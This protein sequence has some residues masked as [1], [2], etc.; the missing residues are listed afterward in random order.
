MRADTGVVSEWLVGGVILVALILLLNPFGFIMTSAFILSAI[1]L[2]AVAVISF[3]VFV[4]RE[5]PRDEREVINVSKAGR[6]SYLVGGGVIVA[7]IVYQTITHQLDP[8]L[9]AVLGAMVIT[10]LILAAWYHQK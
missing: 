9:P 1:M 5:R 7:A 4:W 10:K 2:L 6:L 3:A 8:A